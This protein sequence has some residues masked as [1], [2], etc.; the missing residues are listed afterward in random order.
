MLKRLIE[1]GLPRDNRFALGLF[2]AVLE[3]AFAVSL[4]AVSA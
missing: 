4:L 1:V 2:L 3:G